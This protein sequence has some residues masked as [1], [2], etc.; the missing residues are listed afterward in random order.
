MKW[1]RKGGCGSQ[2]AV[3]SHHIN[4]ITY[5]Q[6]HGNQWIRG[7]FWIFGNMSALLRYAVASPRRQ[8]Q[9]GSQKLDLAY[10]TPRIIVTSMP[11]SE[12]IKT[13][14]RTNL[15]DLREFLER[16]HG[17]KWRVYNFRAE[18][19]GA[20]DDKEFYGQVSHYPFT[21]HSPP[22]FQLMIDAVAAIDKYLTIDERNI[23]VLHCKAGQGRSGTIAC[24]YL[25]V[26]QS[27]SWDQAID[28]F[29]AKRM[30]PGFGPGVSILSQ[31]RYLQYLQ[32]WVTNERSYNPDTI[33]QI[34]QVK[35]YDCQYLDL[36]MTCSTFDRTGQPVQQYSFEEKDIVS[37]EGGIVV[38]EPTGIQLCVGPD[39]QFAFSHE[40]KFYLVHSTAHV[41]FNVFFESHGAGHGSA[42]VPWKEMDGFIGTHK[43]GTQA[44]TA[45]EVSWRVISTN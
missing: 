19:T 28:L 40:K 33:V 9:D 27:L 2:S 39:V 35:L 29:T 1:S 44:F 6:P 21:D 23:A 30:R 41:W 3:P 16:N 13:W 12:F 22:P 5:P 18:P 10:V 45:L 7:F 31:R 14:Y 25:I 24:A 20:Y 15:R 34:E 43:R 17:R 4:P 42:I 36:T 32:T 8:Y 26:K 38:M 37:K 11:T